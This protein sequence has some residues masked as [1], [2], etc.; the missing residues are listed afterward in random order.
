[1]HIRPATRDDA[2]L[3]A[4][5]GMAAYCDHYAALWTPAG[6][7]R[8][9]DAEFAPARIAADLAGDD[10]RWLLAFEERGCAIGFAKTRARSPLPVADERGLELQKIYFRGDAVGRGHGARLLAAVV[11]GA[12]ADGEPLVW[13]DV[14]RSNERGVRFYERHGFVRRGQVPFATDRG[15]IGMWVMSRATTA[16]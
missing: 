2:M 15:E 14:L 9:L 7:A 10:V 5:L 11:D 13:L 8:Y 6:L 1:M 3:V 12:R 4:T 16:T